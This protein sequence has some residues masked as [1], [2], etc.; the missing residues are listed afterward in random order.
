MDYNIVEKALFGFLLILVVA[1]IVIA[2]IPNMLLFL[3]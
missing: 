3:V 1:S 2:F